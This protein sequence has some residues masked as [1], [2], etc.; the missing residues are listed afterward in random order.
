M[1]LK[2]ILL[3]KEE[4]FEQSIQDWA[5]NGSIPVNIFDG[6]NSLT[7]E[8]DAVVLFHEDYNISKENESVKELFLNDSKFAHTIDINGTLMA[9]VS[10][11]VFWL[12]NHKPKKVLVIGDDKLQNNEK[13][14]K[15][16]DQLIKRL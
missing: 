12:E 2:Q 7:E 16:L 13:F 9:A 1:L 4:L 14:K 8:A 11:F 10:S 3:R 15:Y 6:S 5:G